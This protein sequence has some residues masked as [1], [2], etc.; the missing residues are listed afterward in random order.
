MKTLFTIP[1]L[2]TIVVTGIIS[3]R[4]FEKAHY[5]LSALLT[6]AS[7]LSISMLVVLLKSKRMISQ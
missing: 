5:D 3:C 6:V 2:V 1:M 7:Y 4:L